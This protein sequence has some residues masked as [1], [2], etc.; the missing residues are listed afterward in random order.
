MLDRLDSFKNYSMTE[1]QTLVKLHY[2]FCQWSDISTYIG[3]FLEKDKYF[4]D[5]IE[6]IGN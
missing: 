4:C 6:N 1:I 2:V 3:K 5:N